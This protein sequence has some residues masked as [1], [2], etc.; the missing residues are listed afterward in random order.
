MEDNTQQNNNIL[1][2]IEES[3]LED[4]DGKVLKYTNQY[5]NNDQDEDVLLCKIISLIKLEKYKEA[6]HL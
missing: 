4:L 5:L 1:R 3:I 6:L 2:K